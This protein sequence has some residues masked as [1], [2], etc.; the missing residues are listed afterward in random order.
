LVLLEDPDDRHAFLATVMPEFQVHAISRFIEA[1]GSLDSDD[2]KNLATAISECKDETLANTTLQSALDKQPSLALVDGIAEMLTP[3]AWTDGLLELMRTPQGQMT[4]LTPSQ[5][6]FRAHAVQKLIEAGIDLDIGIL[7]LCPARSCPALLNQV[8]WSINDESY[9]EAVGCWLREARLCDG[10]GRRLIVEAA[11]NMH[12]TGN[13]MSPVM[14]E[15]LPAVMR[16]RLCIF[17][18]N[19]YS[20]LDEYVVRGGIK[21]MCVDAYR[22]SWRGYDRTLKAAL[23]LLALPLSKNSAKAFLDANDALIGEIVRQFNEC[24]AGVLSSF[25]LGDELQALLQRC[26]SYQYVDDLS[27]RGFCDGRWW[28][29]ASAV[30]CHAGMSRPEGGRRKCDSLRPST[31]CAGMSG[32][33]LPNPDDQFMAALLANV[34]DA[35][36]GDVNVGPW[37]D[38]RESLGLVEYAYRVSGY[39]NKMAAALPHMVCR[40]CGARLRLNYEYPRKSL[41]GESSNRGLNL[42]ALSATV[43]SC[44]NAGDGRAHDV[45][46]YIHYCLNCH[47]IIDSRECKMRDSEGYYLCMYCGAS[48]VFKPATACPACGN[49]DPRTLRYYTGSLRDELNYLTVEPRS[50]EVLVVCKARGCKYDAREYTSQFE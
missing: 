4:L 35:M 26:A 41:Y 32:L 5:P 43:C 29:S 25:V 39:V 48:K 7:T 21:K 1:G 36:G 30:W 27:V 50:G 15:H 46:V 24:E 12:D 28:E 20:E 10:E 19:H 16:I 3:S 9:A 33:E 49:T 23:L 13:L 22:C 8:Q 14:W 17:W 42:P 34:C 45:D 18:S 31:N 37:L 38:S 6:S 40:G 44:P 11:E 47:R 2:A